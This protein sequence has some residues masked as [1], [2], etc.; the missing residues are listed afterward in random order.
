MAPVPGRDL[1]GPLRAEWGRAKGA[2]TEGL[3]TPHGRTGAL[4]FLSRSFSGPLLISIHF[5]SF[6]L[7]FQLEFHLELH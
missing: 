5:N 4:R 7:L 3:A 1:V 6:H 2:A